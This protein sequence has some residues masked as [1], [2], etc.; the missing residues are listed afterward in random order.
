MLWSNDVFGMMIALVVRF[1]AAEDA[2]AG[3]LRDWIF[4]VEIFNCYSLEDVFFDCTH[5]LERRFNV[6]LVGMT[7]IIAILRFLWSC[8]A[9]GVLGSRR[10]SITVVAGSFLVHV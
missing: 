5:H 2:G 1:E 3:V 9:R 7:L 4:F 10:W 6:G 8:I